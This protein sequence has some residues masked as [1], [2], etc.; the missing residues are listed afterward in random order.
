MQK[1][2]LGDD[3]SDTLQSPTWLDLEA[4]ADVE[5]TSEDPLYPIESALLAETEQGWHAA[6]AGKQMIRLLFHQPQFVQC[7]ALDFV[8]SECQRTQE[9]VLR[10]FQNNAELCHDMVRQ[11]WN[12]S[13]A[14]ST[15]ESEV[16]YINK[17][18][19]TQMELIITP[20]IQ[21]G[22]AKAS[23]KRMRIA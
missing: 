8:E 22:Q 5:V 18:N 6:V 16:H 23:L 17:D 15:S 14:G 4:I 20:D 2:I 3:L 1:R 12:F 19:V 11:Q 10:L 13:P 21:Y 7:V 9:Y